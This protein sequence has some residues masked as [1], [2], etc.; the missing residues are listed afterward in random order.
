M[1]LTLEMRRIGW[2]DISIAGHRRK[3][4]RGT[5]D[6]QSLLQVADRCKKARNHVYLERTS[7]V[8]RERKAPG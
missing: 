1:I 2:L 8:M 5:E 7:F 6:G 4:V 3:E